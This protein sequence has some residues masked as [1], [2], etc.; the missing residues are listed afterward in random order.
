MFSILTTLGKW[1]P[2]YEIINSDFNLEL[3]LSLAK[4]LA[5]E[6]TPKESKQSIR[7]LK[8]AT[9]N[10]DL[11]YEEILRNMMSTLEPSSEFFLGSVVALGHIA[12]ERSEG[13]CHQVEDLMLKVQ[14]TLILILLLLQ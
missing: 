7:C 1:K 2:L 3:L 12:I 13:K 11:V 6:G 8:F 14:I 5:I 10:F 4:K 9:P